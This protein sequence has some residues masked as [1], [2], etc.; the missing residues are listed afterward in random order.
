M[1]RHTAR[2]P[3]LLHS[4]AQDAITPKL[5]QYP[6][7][8]EHQMLQPTA[9]L[10]KHFNAEFSFAFVQTNRVRNPIPLMGDPP[11]RRS[12]TSPV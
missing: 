3:K 12:V 1:L 9:R 10:P 8:I 5:R 7:W 11:L 6:T 2:L 4:E